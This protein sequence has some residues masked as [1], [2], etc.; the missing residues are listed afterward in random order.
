MKLV[1]H[2]I[3]KSFKDKSVLKGASYT[4]EQGKIHALLGRNGSGKTTLFRILYGD[5]EAD[6]GDFY[7]EDEDKRVTISYKDIGMIFAENMLP[8]F[9]TG[10]EYVKFYADINA[11]EGN[12]DIHSYFDQLEFSQ[13]DRHRLI[14]EYSSGMKSKIAIISILISKPKIIL[15]D[16]PLTALDVVASLEIKNQF[17]TLKDDHIV[18]MS[19]HIIQLAKDICDDVVLLHNGLLRH[20]ET[21][22]SGKD[23]DQSLLDALTEE[24]I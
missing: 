14:R 2:G 20:F 19:T 12:P 5:L 18:I 16:E 15:L 7:L 10:Y 21:L 17:M 13:E 9:L 22:I 1:I 23:F 8:D 24:E 4:F 6:S 3:E 11:S